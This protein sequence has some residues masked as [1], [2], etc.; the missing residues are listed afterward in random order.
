V[1]AAAG[2][3][4]AAPLLPR[5]EGPIHVTVEDQEDRNRVVASRDLVV[6]V[7]R[8]QE[9]VALTQV[10]FDPAG[11]KDRLEVRLRLR[12][13]IPPPPVEVALAFPPASDG[14]LTA[15]KGTLQGKLPP[16]RDELLLFAE[17]VRAAG[18][19]GEGRFGVNVDGWARAYSFRAT[20]AGRGS[21]STP[22]QLEAPAIRLRVGAYG[23]A[24][25]TFAVP[26]EVDNAPMRSSI[27]VSLGRLDGGA[28]LAEATARRPTPRER[29]IRFSPMGAEGALVF[30][31]AWQ[32]WTV[33]LDTSRI[34]GPRELRAR[35]LDS[36]GRE[37]AL[38][39]RSITLGDR[40]PAEVAFIDPPARAWRLAPLPLR[41]RGGD[42]VVGVKEVFFFVGKPVGDKVPENV[43]REPGV[44]V[45][46]TRQ[47][48]AVKLPLPRDRA[49]PTDVSVQ[50]V[51][52]VGLSTFATTTVDLLETDPNLAKLGTIKGKVLEGERGQEG[53][54]VVL[55][56]QRGAE[57]GRTKSGDGGAYE[58]KDLAPGK[59]RV[60]AAKV[61]SGRVGTAPRDRR[62]FLDVAAGA[63]V[64]ADVA[65]FL[66]GR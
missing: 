32:D 3:A 44:P 55:T 43:R 16:T 23:L 31:A 60:A 22:V 59:Y 27:E 66:R 42:G 6:D 65:L 33:A 20:L 17:G 57:K 34:R 51:N 35:L 19:S 38:A 47:V 24:G 1:P 28:F 63:T 52:Q 2:A 10:R 8:P 4:V 45:D 37:L 48:W 5:L 56:D 26:L 36:A 25:P 9:Y 41:A 58:F 49:G 54:T 30:E 18:E 14:G 61:S 40:P 39:A 29:I 21:P 13:T 62:G 64:T 7:A 12:Q 50:F 15:G 53:L 11:G 46:A